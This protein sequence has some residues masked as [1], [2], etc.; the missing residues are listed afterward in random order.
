[1]VELL[2]IP[3]FDKPAQTAEACREALGEGARLVVDDGQPWLEVP[4]LRLRGYLVVE[5]GLVVAM[6]FEVGGDGRGAP[7]VERAAEALGYEVH[8]DDDEADDE[9]D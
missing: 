2:L 5:G 3:A 9:G 1:M 4:A 7:T 8:P 6:N